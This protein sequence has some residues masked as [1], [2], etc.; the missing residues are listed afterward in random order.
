LAAAAVL[1]IGSGVLR[2]QPAV[3]HARQSAPF[4]LPAPTGPNAIGVA[5][6]SVIDATR[7]ESFNPGSRRQVRVNAW[8]PA[9]AATGEPAPYLLETE[10]DAQTLSTLLRSP[11]AYDALNL[12]VTHGRIGAPI[13]DRP[14]R[15]PLLLFSHGYIGNPAAYT[16]LL[17][18]LAS[19]GYIVISIVHPYEAT[20]ARLSDGTIVTMLDASGGLRAGIRAVLD[21]WTAEDDMMAA[22]TKASDDAER[23]RLMRGYL[24]RLSNTFLALRRWSDDTKA[25]VEGMRAASASTPPGVLAG[26]A[27]FERIGV[28]GHSM[29]GVAAGQFC[30]ED[31]RCR[32]GLNLDGIPQYGSMIGAT[33]ERPFMMVYSA[34]PNRAGA[35]D[36]IYQ[37]AASPYYRVDVRHTLHL[38]FTDIP[39]WGG[40]LKERGAFGTIPPERAAEI[41]RDIVR[42]FF[43]QELLGRPSP[44]LAGQSVHPEVTVRTIR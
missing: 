20:A 44:L 24:I 35:S 26:R 29:G 6:W 7:G 39:F 3:V 30:V 27:D 41:T 32:A 1:T 18:D 17:E 43:D 40:P 4:V 9:Q 33:L 31:A 8:Y 38:D 19:H 25:V 13:I 14:A 37:R 2:V 12:V 11:G 5:A 42:Q 36:V 23:Y 16:A 15:L 10:A 22:I 21:E 28:F 34:R